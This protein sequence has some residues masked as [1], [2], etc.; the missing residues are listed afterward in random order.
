MGRSYGGKRGSSISKAARD[1][2]DAELA[3][4][5]SP[6][7]RFDVIMAA[8]DEQLAAYDAP[9]PTINDIVAYMGKLRDVCLHAK[10]V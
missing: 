3:A 6:F 9:E 10:A 8:V 1:F 7:D 2:F 4:E 5:A